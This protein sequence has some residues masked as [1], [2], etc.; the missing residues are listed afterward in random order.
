[1]GLVIAFLIMFPAG[2]IVA[3][4]Y[5]GDNALDSMTTIL[6]AKP[7]NPQAQ[8]KAGF[9]IT[10]CWK[11]VP[12]DKDYLVFVH[13]LDK[14]GKI[15]LQ[16]DH[17]PPIPTSKWEGLVE[18]T[19]TI[20]LP[21][22]QP[23]DKKTIDVTLPEGEYSIRAG[24]YDK[25]EGKKTLSAGHGV[26]EISEGAYKIGVLSIDAK[27]PTPKLDERT[28]DLTDYHL[29]FNEEFD[30]LSVS[31][32]GPCGNE[33]TRWI[34]HTPWKGDFG[35]ARFTDPES[36]FPFTI[37][38]GILRIEA[39]EENGKWRSGLLS[40]VDPD[41]NGF[42]QKYGY[43]E[44]RAKFPEGPGTW[45][46]FWLMG[47]LSLKGN[48]GPRINPEVDV[49]EYYGHWP[50]R[51]SHVLHLWGR[52]GAESRHY[53]TEKI[54]VFGLDRNFHTYGMMIDEESMILYVDGVEMH[55]R[56]TPEPVKTPLFPLVNLALGPGWPIDKT[57][58][59]SYMYVDYV[60][61]YSK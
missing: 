43:F 9:R 20:P 60:K 26:T 13:F 35:D 1:M 27:A 6:M 40:A 37:N 61:V 10:Y 47:T 45:P 49:F 25:K 23:K 38:G 24:L 44:C 16:D 54:V 21:V 8:P 57:P 46:A 12:M 51:F 42:K 7:E 22:W 15:I 55:R 17:K 14:D 28:L 5:E 48:S 3:Q 34:A 59:P 32:W 39:R 36:D 58:N 19:H 31:A 2:N 53:D 50:N 41:G 29:T 56:E 11:T 18:Y 33:G 30:D 4:E 52:D